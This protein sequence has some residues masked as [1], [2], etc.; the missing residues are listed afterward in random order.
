MNKN[1]LSWRL[2]NKDELVLMYENLHLKGIG[3]FAV[4]NY[5]SS[6][7]INS[8]N[9]WLQLFGFGFQF[10]NSKS[11]YVRVRVARVFKLQEGEKYSIGQETETGFIFDIQ[12]DIIFEC[13]KEDEPELM[14]WDEAM[15]KFGGKK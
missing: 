15:E 7:E 12:R 4:G 11:H 13:K 6:F 1:K 3:G 2:P 5:W 10:S 8:F 9:A 14:T